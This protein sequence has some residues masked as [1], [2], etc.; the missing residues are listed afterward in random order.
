[1]WVLCI[2][3]VIAQRERKLTLGSM[4]GGEGIE[5]SKKSKAQHNCHVSSTKSFTMLCHPE[6]QTHRVLQT[7]PLATAAPRREQEM[8]P[9]VDVPLVQ[10]NRQTARAP[11]PHTS[12]DVLPP[13]PIPAAHLTWLCLGSQA[14]PAPPAFVPQTAGK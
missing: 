12:A 11:P 1:M 6:T 9:F 5:Q 13:Q 7:V 10:A 14:D 4:R 2:R 3:Q 8:L